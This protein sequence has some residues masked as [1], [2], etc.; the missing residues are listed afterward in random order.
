MLQGNAIV[1]QSGGPTAAINATLAGVIFGAMQSSDIHT[2]YGARNGIEGVLKENLINLS[3]REWSHD[4]IRLLSATPA[5]ILGSCRHK[6]SDANEYE[7]IVDVF[8]KYN[9]RFFFYIG[10]NDSMDT[11]AKLAA[12][13]QACDYEM[14]VIG[15]P[16]TIDNDLCGTHH[17]PGYGSA[18]K[19]VAT[20]MQ[21]I[22]RDAQ[23]YTKPS[24]TIVEIMGRDAGWLTA[25]AALAKPDFVYLPEKKCD[26]EY[27]VR[28]IENAMAHHPN[29]VIAVSEGLRDMTGKY[30]S[31]SGEPDAFGHKMLCGTAK[32]IAD[33]VSEQI[34]CKT[35]AIELNVLQRCASHCASAADIEESLLLGSAAVNTAL[36][37]ASGQMMSI[38]HGFECV[39]AHDVANRVK[40]VPLEF[41]AKQG[42][43]VTEKCLAYIKPLIQGEAPVYWENGLPKYF[44]L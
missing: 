34:G 37:G 23:V 12:Y 40:Q 26:V 36:H 19:F 22:I 11:V 16:K 2:L 25:A 44:Q 1:G 38:N 41:I 3:E 13:T 39:P 42:N 18:A 10:G 6:L 17:T 27:V 4:D 43:N 28:D 15:I 9:I 20:T 24:A 30:I 31:E 35:R 29:I 32:R 21:E 14:S 7:K 8:K 33:I 5:A